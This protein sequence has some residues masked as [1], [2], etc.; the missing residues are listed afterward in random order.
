MQFL[1]E[2]LS[3][4]LSSLA[5]GFEG[6]YFHVKRRNANTNDIAWFVYCRAEIEEGRV[7]LSRESR[8]VFMRDYVIEKFPAWQVEDLFRNWM[9]IIIAL[10]NEKFKGF[11]SV[12][13]KQG[14]RSVAC[15]FYGL[16]A[17]QIP[18]GSFVTARII[19]MLALDGDTAYQKIEEYLWEIL[20]HSRTEECTGAHCKCMQNDCANHHYNDHKK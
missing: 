9:K 3:R 15:R 2:K 16:K 8:F 4:H 7:Y 12:C 19:D 5:P 10:P 6:H 17:P 13:E 18:F 20:G 14:C 11:C 1:S